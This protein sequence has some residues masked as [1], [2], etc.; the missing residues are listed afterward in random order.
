MVPPLVTSIAAGGSLKSCHSLSTVTN[1]VLLA[2]HVVLAREGSLLLQR[3]AVLVVI[4]YGIFFNAI[5]DRCRND[6]PV[7]VRHYHLESMSFQN[8]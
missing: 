7:S 2:Y 8:A 1:D 5:T 3:D 4:H 6:N